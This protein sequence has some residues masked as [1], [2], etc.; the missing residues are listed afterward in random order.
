MFQCENSR[1]PNTPTERKASG[2]CD[3]VVV[4]GQAV[5]GNSKT[6]VDLKGMIFRKIGVCLWLSSLALV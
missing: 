1:C 4:L 6:G 3:E 5:G 2:R